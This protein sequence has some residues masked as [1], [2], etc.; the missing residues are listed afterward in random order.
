MSLFFNSPPGIPA[1]ADEARKNAASYLTGVPTR[2]P[3]QA[4]AVLESQPLPENFQLSMYPSLNAAV[5]SLGPKEGQKSLFA[6][7]TDGVTVKNDPLESP[8]GLFKM[9]SGFPSLIPSL[10][11]PHLDRQGLEGLKELKNVSDGLFR[12]LG[13]SISGNLPR[14]GLLRNIYCENGAE[15][16]LYGLQRHRAPENLDRLNPKDPW[17]KFV[18]IAGE[19]VKDFRLLAEDTLEFNLGL[20]ADI[21]APIKILS[22]NN[23]EEGMFLRW[24]Q[25]FFESFDLQVNPRLVLINQAVP[26]GG[27]R[28]EKNLQLSYNQE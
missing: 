9:G 10:L 7:D 27:M 20:V 3:Q 24:M 6:F 17:A 28:M 11:G 23:G 5:G 1:L 13:I 18:T 8:F 22:F 15:D 4:L 16:Y 14:Q 25:Q 26:A 19:V 21:L 12:Y 2:T